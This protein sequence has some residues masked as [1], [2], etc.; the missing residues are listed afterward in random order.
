MSLIFMLRDYCIL[1]RSVA[2][3]MIE[4]IKL[5]ELPQM[6]LGPLVQVGF[7]QK[8]N[9]YSNGLGALTEQADNISDLFVAGMGGMEVAGP[10]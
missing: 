3:K 6:K 5:H 10:Y 1:C 8:G 7:C 2:V 9:E 4:E